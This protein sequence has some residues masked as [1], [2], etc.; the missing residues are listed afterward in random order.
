MEINGCLL[1]P[2]LLIKCVLQSSI[3]GPLLFLVYIIKLPNCL[4][5]TN[6]IYADDT[7]IFAHKKS[8][9]EV[10]SLLNSDPDNRIS[11]CKLNQLYINP[12]KT[13]FTF[14]RSPMRNADPTPSITLQNDVIHTS[15]A[16][17][18]RV[19]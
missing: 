1:Q 11:W 19:Y 18:L 9:T 4:K 3:L 5:F 15:P 6:N 7:T 14:F 2:K 17:M 13:H 16:A 10:L 8:L 12:A